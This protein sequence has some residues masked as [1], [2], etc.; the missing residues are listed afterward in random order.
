MTIRNLSYSC[1]N[2]HLDLLHHFASQFPPR[3]VTAHFYAGA[4]EVVD[5]TLQGL[6]TRYIYFFI[7]DNVFLTQVLIPDSKSVENV[8]PCMIPQNFDD[9]K[10]FSLHCANTALLY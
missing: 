3:K 6:V 8:D 5:T 10:G 7:D 2:R 4:A 1:L 9:P